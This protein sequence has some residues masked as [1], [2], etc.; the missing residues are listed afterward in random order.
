MSSVGCSAV[1]APDVDHRLF[2]VHRVRPREREERAIRHLGP[3]DQADDRVQLVLLGLG[4]EG[5]PVG[6][7]HVARHGP[8]VVPAFP[9]EVAQVLPQRVRVGFRVGVV[10]QDEV[11]AGEGER[12]VEPVGLAAVLDDRDDPQSGVGVLEFLKDL[13]GAVRGRVVD[14]DDLVAL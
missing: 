14:D 6:C 3:F 9:L 1:P 8:D 5:G 7:Q 10:G 2:A 13:R 11:P 12:D 4:D